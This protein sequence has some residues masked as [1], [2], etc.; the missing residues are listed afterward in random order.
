VL[1]QNFTLS[2]DFEIRQT[3]NQLD[4]ADISFDFFD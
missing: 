3:L 4:V 1:F 2:V